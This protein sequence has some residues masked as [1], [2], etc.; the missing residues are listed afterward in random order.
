MPLISA[1]TT[2]HTTVTT[3]AS[4]LNSRF[5]D[6]NTGARLDQTALA[7]DALVER[8][9]FGGLLVLIALTAVPIGV[10][11]SWWDRIVEGAI[12]I[13]GACWIVTIL[14]S[15]RWRVHMMLAPVAGL[16]LLACLQILPIWRGSS[17]TAGSWALSAD[18]FETRRFVIKSLA[19][20]LTL[21]MLMH[22]TSTRKR[23][24]ALV[25]LVV[26]VGAASAALAILLLLAPATEFASLWSNKLQGESF[27]QFANRNHFALLMEMSLGPALGLAIFASGR[28]ILCLYAAT[29]LLISGA[30]VLANSRGGIVS[31]LVQYA[32]F[33]WTW[34]GSFQRSSLRWTPYGHNR[35]WRMSETL[36]R[37]VLLT[38]FFLG[39]ACAAVLWLGGEPLRHRLESVP[40]EFRPSNVN[41]GPRRLEIW[42]AT[43]NLIAD[44]PVLGSGM[45]AYKTAIS[46]YFP[47]STLLAAAAGA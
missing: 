19:L 5:L 45:G 38:V 43:G 20:G 6:L 16:I 46:G 22:Y 2:I 13:L 33:S 12:F 41:S 15:K 26:I 31:M 10:V 4:L 3:I 14:L 11:E 36:A 28:A 39:V 47:A 37:R 34:F 32:F 1:R 21:S 44:R 17:S 27:G 40:R 24:L 35:F 18:A 7:S 9:I 30:L 23:L 42:A 25:H 8:A 29:V